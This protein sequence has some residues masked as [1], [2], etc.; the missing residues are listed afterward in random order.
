VLAVVLIALVTEDFVQG[1]LNDFFPRVG[2][3]LQSSFLQVLHAG[4]KI[5]GMENFPAS[6]Q[7][8]V[9]DREHVLRTEQAR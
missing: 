1:W 2:L 9:G 5:S 6:I 4:L 7:R 8:A 3:A